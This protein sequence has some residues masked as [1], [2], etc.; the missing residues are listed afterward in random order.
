[1]QRYNNVTMLLSCPPY[2]SVGAWQGNQFAV[3][4][5]SLPGY[6][7]IGDGDT[8]GREILHDGRYR[9]QTGLRP[10]EVVPPRIQKSQILGLNF[11][12]LTRIS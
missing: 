1:M 3:I 10:F 4:F 6:R 9:F 8:D 2:V 11:G 7:Y 12:H 5:I